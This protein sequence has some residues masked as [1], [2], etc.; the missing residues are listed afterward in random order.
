[1]NNKAIGVFDSGVGGLTVAKALS[2]V[3]PNEDLV[4]FGDTA[5]LPYGDKSP[6]AIQQ[7]S[8]R[9][10]KYLIEEHQ[11]KAILVACNSAS[12]VAYEALKAEYGT[13]IPIVNVIDPVAQHVG[14]QTDFKSIGVIG[15]RATVA[16]KTY[17]N[18]IQSANPQIAVKSLATPLLVPIIEEGLGQT[19]ISL[20]ALKHYLKSPE[21]NAVDALILGCTHYPHIQPEIEELKNAN[22]E[23]VNS[24][25][26][27][28]NHLKHVLS[29]QG[30]LNTQGHNPNYSF[31]V[32]DYTEVFETIAQLMFGKHID[33]VEQN[34]W[35]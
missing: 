33:L 2:K 14:L 29:E 20:A 16:S 5:H 8:L 11:V 1:M 25:E 7:Y 30:L 15:T 27:V 23:L 19:A 35:K 26:I 34:I 6:E 18:K 22:V 10:A 13:L 12:A 21:L 28:A 31:L 32:S 17:T 24:P 4:Y 9:I 3:L